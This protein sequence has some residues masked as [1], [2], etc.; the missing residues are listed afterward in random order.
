MPIIIRLGTRRLDT[1]SFSILSV[2]FSLDFPWLDL[3]EI[4]LLLVSKVA[5]TTEY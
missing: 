5:L 3:R 4:I 2:D 1:G